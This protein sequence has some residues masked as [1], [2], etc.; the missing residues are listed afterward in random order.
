MVTALLASMVWAASPPASVVAGGPDDY[1]TVRYARLAGTQEEIGAQLAQMARQNH[2]V[3]PAK[4]SQTEMD[5]R[6]K[7][8][9]NHW[10][11]QA[12]RAEGVAKTFGYR[13]GIDLFNTSELPYNMDVEPGCSTVFYPARFVTTGTPILS[14]NYDFPTRP[15][16]EL[17]GRRAPK[18]ARGSTADPYVLETIPKDGYATL[19]LAAYDLLGTCMDGIN[20]KGLAVALLADDMA[21]EAVRT[22]E[23]SVNEIELPRLVL[24]KCASAK[25]ARTLLASL[26]FHF[27][28]VPCHYLIADA[29]GDSFVFEYS[30]NRKK[31][32]FIE[33]R[34][35]P[36][37][38]TNH[39]LNR[40]GTD[41]LPAGNSF[42]RYRRLQAEIAM[43]GPKVT[44]KQA[45]GIN[46]CVAVPN[47]VGPSA[48][49]WHAV[50]DLKARS[51]RVSFFL[52]K[53]TGR[54]RRSPYREF[55][56][57]K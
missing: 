40:F 49:M 12:K 25:E 36:Q 23:A 44:P 8:L 57:K 31:R 15:M 9:A 41:N 46:H 45:E 18:G 14:R 39:A 13:L 27:S 6:L 52:G 30:P 1:M 51:V 17:M 48:T 34:G 26:D 3:A 5:A 50:Y 43:A 10:P 47:E 54:E 20:E 55:K 21:G 29:S 7:W 32:F 53:G 28:F 42:D 2:R 33:G 37:I 19:T 22:E 35:K 38:V 56:L 24:E 4:V 11:E 16:A